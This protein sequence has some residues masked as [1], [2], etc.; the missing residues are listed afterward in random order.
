[1]FIAIFQLEDW[2]FDTGNVILLHGHANR[3]DESNVINDRATEISCRKLGL[4]H[5]HTRLSVVNSHTHLR[6]HDLRQNSSERF[7]KGI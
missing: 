5:T 6:F 1:M 2:Q 7:F 3:G 4:S